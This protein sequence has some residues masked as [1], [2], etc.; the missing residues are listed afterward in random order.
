MKSTH[1]FG[2]DFVIRRCK[3]D[4]KR[5]LIYARINVDGERKEISLKEHINANDWNFTNETVKGKSSEVKALN[6]YIDDVRF[7]IKSKYRM[8][9][10]STALITAEAVKQAYLGE[11][12]L[13]KGHKLIELVNY[14]QKIWEAKLKPGGFKNYKTTIEYIRLFAKSHFPSGDIYLSQLTLQVATEFEHYIRNNPIKENASCLGNGLAKHIQ[15]FKRI[16]NWSVELEWIKANPLDNYSC[17]LK[18]SKRKKLTMQ[19]LVTLEAKTFVNPM[20]NYVKDLFLYSAYTGL[21]FVDTLSLKESDFEVELDGP[22]WCK[23]Y[24]TKSDS[25][26]P[27]PLLKSS[28]EIMNKYLM[29][30]KVGG[31]HTV[32]PAITN[33]YVNRC[34]KIIKEA[35]E[36]ATPMTFH[37]AR[38]TF[39][40]TVALKNGVPLETVQMMMGHSKISTT[41]IYADVD[42]EKI[43]VDMTGAEDRLGKKREIILAAHQLKNKIENVQTV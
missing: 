7:K 21:A 43:M 29:D 12:I 9:Q 10:D 38:H 39:A 5:A 6:E 13:Q 32:F 42:E 28:A 2:I 30:A 31:R 35:C 15:R 33:Q 4:N 17:P 40:K 11:H 26:C 36:I 20:L 16:I 25:L 8:L 22:I 27:V 34:L 23:I 37:I 19:E 18:K 1:S 14:Y 41:Q 24:R 3:T